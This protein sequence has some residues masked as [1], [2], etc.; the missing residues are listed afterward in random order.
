MTSSPFGLQPVSINPLRYKRDVRQLAP[1]LVRMVV[2]S[3]A[4]LRHALQKTRFITRIVTCNIYPAIHLS[5]ITARLMR[6]LSPQ[7]LVTPEQLRPRSRVVVIAACI[8]PRRFTRL[9][10]LSWESHLTGFILGVKCLSC[11]VFVAILHLSN[12][13][14]PAL[15]DSSGC[16]AGRSDPSGTHLA[17]RF[18]SRPRWVR[19][20]QSSRTVPRCQMHTLLR[21]TFPHFILNSTREV[22]FE[23]SS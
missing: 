19:G 10:G 6:Q 7:Q 4:L 5:K 21:S 3:N 9:F 11:V 23:K 8:R 15:L 13:A 22:I 20:E 2:R 18:H 14:M 16:L 1:H 12:T 17:T